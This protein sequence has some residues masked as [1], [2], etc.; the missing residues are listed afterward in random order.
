MQP[1]QLLLKAGLGDQILSEV[2]ERV[3]AG[4]A[5]DACSR[6]HEILWGGAMYSVI[7]HWIKR[8][9]VEPPEEM[10]EICEK[11]TGNIK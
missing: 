10:A 5:D 3:L 8:G 11:I 1:L 7:T 9:A 2:T 4:A 6:Y